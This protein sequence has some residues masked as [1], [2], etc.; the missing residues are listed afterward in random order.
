M[1]EIIP[2]EY[3]GRSIRVIRDE[4]GEPWWVAVDVC[5]VLDLTNPSMQ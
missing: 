4:A 5:K 3:Q 2:F 1:Q